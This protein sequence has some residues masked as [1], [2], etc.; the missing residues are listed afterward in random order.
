VDP[1]LRVVEASAEAVALFQAQP[2]PG[3]TAPAGSGG[4]P[5]GWGPL[6]GFCRTAAIEQHARAALQGRAGE[7]ELEAPHF[8]LRLRVRAIP[9]PA[10]WGAFLLFEDLTE[11]R[12]LEAVRADF[13]TNL[14]HELRTPVA[15]LSLAVET[16]QGDLPADQRR[17][18]VGR[19]AEETRYIEGLL[20]TVSELAFL[21][22]QVRLSLEAFGLHE[23]VEETWLRV[24]ARWGEGRLENRV[25]R[26]LLVVAD[27][28]RVAEVLQNLLEN[29][30]RFSPPEAAVEVSAVRRQG[31][32][33][34]TV[35]DH[36]P[37]IP[38]RELPRVFERF[39][40]VD[41]ARTRAG[42]GGSGLGL[43]IARHLV[44]AHGGQIRAEAPAGGGTALVFDLP[45]PG[46]ERQGDLTQP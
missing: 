14:A 13:V 38:P 31:E 19:V 45:E 29:A 27:R 1:R 16:L 26:D 39:Y 17:R 41:R 4:E 44:L 21:E 18:F 36:G 24:V 40:K 37:G 10:G 25:E 43:A 32:V 6:I 33:E 3:S 7:W 28:I 12:R 23:V 8:G 9:L 15:S 42:E 46:L 30:H 2:E 5:S 20:R 22:G 35:R 34:V 11:L